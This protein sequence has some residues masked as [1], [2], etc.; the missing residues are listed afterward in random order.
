MKSP[1]VF[2]HKMN[3]ILLKSEK[4]QYN[5]NSDSLLMYFY[6]FLQRKDCMPL[7]LS[8]E[9]ES[10]T[11]LGVWKI[12]EEKEVLKEQAVLD[13]FEEEQYASFKSEI[14]KKQWLSYR[15]LLKNMLSP[16]PVCL[17]YDAFGKPH[18][19]NNRSYLSI[20]H[21]GDYSAVITS[22]TRP[23]GIDIERLKDRIYRIKD[24]FLTIEEDQNIG[25]NNRLE[26]L[27]II[28]G[29]KESLYKIYGKPDVEF[30]RD[31]FV[32]SFDYL[33]SGKGQCIAG[34]KTP[35]GLGAY[36][37][38]YERISDYMLVYALTKNAGK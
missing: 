13:F 33:C 23:V 31:I 30:Q 21:S 34:M 6:T 37:I 27:Y 17:E 29:A 2:N 16:E 36:N 11:R 24:R 8:R 22:N 28:W 38:F 1:K 4:P 7:I 5:R 10:Q 20:S 14:R 35:E 26:K 9:I 32:G 19:R 3:F 18:L 15:I 12:D 25:E